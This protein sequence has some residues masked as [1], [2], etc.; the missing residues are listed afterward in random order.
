MNLE[1]LS[2]TQNRFGLIT[3]PEARVVDDVNDALMWGAM[4]FLRQQGFK[5]IEVPTLTKITGACENVDTLYSVDH[6]GQEAYLAQTGQLYLEA[7]IPLHSKLWTII[8]SSR[9]EGRPDSRHLNQFQLIEL[10][11]VGSLDA[12]LDNLEGTVKAMLGH[13]FWEQRDTLRKLG[14]L[15]ELKRW[16]ELP[17]VRMTYTRAVD[18][19]NGTPYEF[20][21]GE[22]LS[23]DAEQYLVQENGNNPIFITY[24]PKE[25]KFFNM[26]VNP[27][28]GRVVNSADLI[29][30][31]SGESAG[32]AEREND[33]DMLVK[34]LEESPMFRILSE[35]GKTLEDFKDYL[36]MVREHPILHSGCGIGFSRIS[37]AVLGTDDIRTSTSYPI[38]SDVLY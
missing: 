12:L 23:S 29:M 35:R 3:G 33:Y 7:K 5:W 19:L 26:R 21:W 16:M 30:P 32:A 22:D 2:T 36:E 27:L 24:F 14:R 10:E 38:Q 28:D 4:A 6:F 18:W 37:Q 11:H 20:A 31:Y 1:V 17:F 34:R 8:T 25:I 13:A 15:A 9:A